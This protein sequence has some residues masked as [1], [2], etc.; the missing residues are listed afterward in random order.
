MA[1]IFGFY[2]KIAGGHAIELD[3]T[4]GASGPEVYSQEYKGLTS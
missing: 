4:V 2:P 3:D 1:E